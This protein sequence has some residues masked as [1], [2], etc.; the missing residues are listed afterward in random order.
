MKAS[1]PRVVNTV[2]STVIQRKIVLIDSMRGPY[3]KELTPS[4]AIAAEMHRLVIFF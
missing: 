1:A 4:I 2:P 3:A